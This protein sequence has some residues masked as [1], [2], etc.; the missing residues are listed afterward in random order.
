MARLF[1]AMDLPEDVRRKLGDLVPRDI[2]GLRRV[3]QAQLHLTLHFMAEGDVA[4]VAPALTEVR[5]SSFDL[6]LEKLGSFGRCRRPRVLWIGVEPC[7]GLTRLYLAAGEALRA[8]GFEPETRPFTPHITLARAKAG[9]ARGEMDR[10]LAQEVPFMPVMRI[11]EFH[12]YTSRMIDGGH[13]HSRERTYQL[14]SSRG[15]VE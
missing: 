6:T 8:V 10:F 2:S 9:L 11:T 12:L 4:R 13:V 3:P 14:D 5:A 15:A 1:I 7:A